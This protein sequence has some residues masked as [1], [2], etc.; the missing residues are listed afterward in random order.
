MTDTEVPYTKLSEVDR[1]M[2]KIDF[3]YTKLGGKTDGNIIKITTGYDS[4]KETDEFNRIRYDI[5]H[6]MNQIETLLQD[7]TKFQGDFD[8]RKIIERQKIQA[9]IDGEMQVVKQ[10]L[11]QLN[12]V[13]KFQQKKQN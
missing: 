13:F 11:D 9:K 12:S 2:K 10:N 8:G 3:I 1:L 6:K 4:S 7:R 5:R